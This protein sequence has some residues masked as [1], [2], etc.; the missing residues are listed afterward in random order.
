MPRLFAKNHKNFVEKYYD[1]G[2]KKVIDKKD[3]RT[4]GKDKNN[5]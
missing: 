4:F 2:E 1:I 3:F 5:D